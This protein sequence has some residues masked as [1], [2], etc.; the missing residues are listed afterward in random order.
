MNPYRNC[1]YLL[2]VTLLASVLFAGTIDVPDDYSTIQAAINASVNGGTIIVMPGTYTG[3]GNRD[4]DLLGKLITV[5]S[6]NPDDPN[7]VEATVIDCQGSQAE[8]HRGFYIHSGEPS[9]TTISGLTITN[10]VGDGG[11]G[12]IYVESSTLDI[13]YCRITDNSARDGADASY[14]DPIPAE[15]GVTALPA[16]RLHGDV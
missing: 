4:L 14:M 9:G 8:P 3:S 11:G 13:T 6:M 15:A 1:T 2:F 16:G 10:G 5:R 12:G 7:V